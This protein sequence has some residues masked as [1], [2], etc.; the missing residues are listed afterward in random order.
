MEEFE[1]EFQQLE[2]SNKVVRRKGL[3]QLHKRLEEVVR[4][5]EGRE[6]LQATAIRALQDKWGW[7]LRLYD[8]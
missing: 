1:E 3:E 8:M 5:E 2:D 7:W 6:R 4:E